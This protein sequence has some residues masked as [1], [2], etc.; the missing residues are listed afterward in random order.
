MDEEKPVLVPGDPER[1]HMRK[2]DADGGIQYHINQLTA[3]D[4]L[5]DKLKIP[6]V[7]TL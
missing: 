2:V 4:K 1:I 3:C 6:K 7:G 5:A